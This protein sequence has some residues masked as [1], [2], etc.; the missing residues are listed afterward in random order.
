MMMMDLPFRVRVRAGIKG[1]HDDDDPDYDDNDPT[2][3]GAF[4][5]GVLGWQQQ[6]QMR[7][8]TMLRLVPSSNGGNLHGSF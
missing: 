4:L 1:G 5:F 3:H 2:K 7:P 6:N 8:P